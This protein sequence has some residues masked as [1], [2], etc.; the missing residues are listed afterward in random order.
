MSLLV[1]DNR[2]IT[3]ALRDGMPTIGPI[4]GM[5]LSSNLSGFTEPIDVGTFTEGIIFALVSGKSGSPT[6]DI[7]V[8]YSIDGKNFV[9]SGD[10]FTQI[11]ANG[12]SFKK[13]TANF[14]KFI[15]L[16]V[17]LASGGSY[18]ATIGIALKG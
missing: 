18:L 3:P 10:S 17:K 14:G 16:R 8:Q 7:D 1:R 13:L 11:T 5:T 15:R 9:D 2:I 4:S 12:L 6:L